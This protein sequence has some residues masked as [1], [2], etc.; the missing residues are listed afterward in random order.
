MND[1]Y[2]PN[3][4]ISSKY[5]SMTNDALKIFMRAYVSQGKSLRAAAK[6]IDRF[7][8]TM[9]RWIKRIE[10]SPARTP[11]LKRR[12]RTAPGKVQDRG[13]FTLLEL[14]N[15]LREEF[16]EHFAVPV[17][18]TAMHKV[19]SDKLS[20]S[21]KKAEVYNSIR[22]HDDIITQRFNYATRIINEG[23]NLHLSSILKQDPRSVD[24]QELLLLDQEVEY[25]NFWCYKPPWFR[26]ARK[27][28]V[29]VKAF[30]WIRNSHVK[31]ADEAFKARY[32]NAETHNSYCKKIFPFTFFRL[33]SN[34]II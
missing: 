5:K 23:F 21:L 3:T 9:R 6:E 10:E 12:G 22:T 32:L 27:T 29:V 28:S 14:T 24:Q 33:R 25:D 2:I 16:P 7:P 30:E 20:F 34:I 13:G 4:A 15:A 11:V 17:S 8:L 31:I 18:I 26:I 19:L 1:P